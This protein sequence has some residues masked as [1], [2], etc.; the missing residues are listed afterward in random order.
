MTG[1]RTYWTSRY[2]RG[3]QLVLGRRWTVSRNPAVAAQELAERVGP[4]R[5]HQWA[6]DVVAALERR[7]EA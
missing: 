2:V 6:A 4:D 5:A 7:R 1:G 3:R